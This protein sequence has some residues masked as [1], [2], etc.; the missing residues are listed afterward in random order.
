MT[1]ISLR[2]AA[3]VL[4]A[5]SCGAQTIIAGS[6]VRD[7]GLGLPLGDKRMA[8]FSQTDTGVLAAVKE[9]APLS[10]SRLYWTPAGG[11]RRQLAVI[12]TGGIVA[13]A[14]SEYV[15]YTEPDSGRVWG[16]LVH[17]ADGHVVTLEDQRGFHAAAIHGDRLVVAKSLG[18]ARYR[19]FELVLHDCKT[20]KALAAMP[21]PEPTPALVLHFLGQE[22][23]LAVR[24]RSASLTILSLR[25]DTIST[26]RTI[27]LSGN[28][29]Q[30]SRSSR[31]PA[32]QEA[33][34][35]LSLADAPP[36]H[37]RFFVGSM[38]L[39]DGSR[40]VEFDQEG[41]QTQSYRLRGDRNLFLFPDHA[42]VSVV[43]DKI[44][45]AA[46]DGRVAYFPSPK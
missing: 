31:R 17:L 33:N 21:W 16:R 7:L 34:L 11:E 3:I 25:G 32:M 43:D 39:E 42:H 18:G 29:I 38:R 40:L 4:I 36:E 45:I 6:E 13:A 30:L 28:E 37:Y 14:N 8:Y 1:T 5:T 35:V 20:G 9:G 23:L 24:L 2:Q 12:P 46:P 22:K 10:P 19:E 15:L 41:K 27:D 26:D 44:A